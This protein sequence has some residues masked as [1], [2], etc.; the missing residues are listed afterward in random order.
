MKTT[1]STYLPSDSEERISEILNQADG[2][3]EEVSSIP[4]SDS[5][6]YS[7]GYYV[8]CTAV[9]IDIRGSSELPK[10]HTRPVL[11]KIFRAY[12][13]ECVAVLNSSAKCSEVFISG[14]CVSGIFDTPYKPDIDMAFETAAKLNSVVNILNW[15]FNDKTYTTIRCGIGMAYGRAL[16]LKAGFKGSGIN[17]IVWM[18]DVVNDASNLCHDANKNGRASLQVSSSAKNNLREAYQKWLRPVIGIPFPLPIVE[19]Y[20]GDIVNKSMEEWLSDRKAKQE[21]RSQLAKALM[22]RQFPFANSILGGL[23]DTSYYGSASDGLFGPQ[24]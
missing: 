2:S 13:S 11:A 14:D 12:I 15:L 21:A 16:M 18:G 22:T 17:D 4:S 23:F 10:K 7:N 5:L 24:K 19:N 20:E 1:K 6:T 3:F 8:N 9:F